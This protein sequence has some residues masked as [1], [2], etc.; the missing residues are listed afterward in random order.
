MAVLEGH[1]EAVEAVAGLPDG[2]LLA[3]GS[4]DGAVRVW[5]V[6]ARACV[7]TLAGK[8]RGRVLSLAVL[9]DGRLAS[10]ASDQMVRLWDVGTRTC[11]GVLGRHSSPVTAL[12]VLHDGRLVAGT[13]GGA[14]WLWDTRPAVAA[15]LVRSSRAAGSAPPVVVCGLMPH[16]VAALVQLPDGRLVSASGGDEGMVHL[17]AL[18]PPPVSVD[19]R[20]PGGR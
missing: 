11:V 17:L 5:D 9:A 7:A 10:G 6:G 13:E 18:P 12:A 15:A 4:A 19:C 14:I 8:Q 20:V 2:A 1:T 16:N 3:S